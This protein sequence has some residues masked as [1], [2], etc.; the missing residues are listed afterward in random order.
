MVRQIIELNLSGRQIKEICTQELTE[1]TSSDKESLP[2]HTKRFI[3]LMKAA[4][5]GTA[6]ELAQVLLAEEKDIHLAR[7]RLRSLLEFLN[8]AEQYLSEG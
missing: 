8:E 5:M 3:R 4:N 1:T 7:A 2:R 6:Q